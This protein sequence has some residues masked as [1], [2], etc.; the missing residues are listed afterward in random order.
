LRQHPRRPPAAENDPARRTFNLDMVA[1]G[2][3]ASFLVYASLSQNDDLNLLYEEAKAA[4]TG[5]LGAWSVHGTPEP[6]RRA[7]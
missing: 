2:R 4:W 1:T 3:A 5:R 7:G 6:A